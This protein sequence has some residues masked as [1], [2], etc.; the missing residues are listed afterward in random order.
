MIFYFSG[1]GNSFHA[2]TEIAKSQG[3]LAVSIAKE[4]DKGT[5]RYQFHKNELIG[6]VYPIYAWGPPQIVLD[7]IKKIKINGEKPY[8]FSISTC[9]GSEGNAT[10]LLQKVLLSKGLSLDSAFSLVMPDNY[11]F[12]A[13]VCSKDKAEK[14]LKSAEERLQVINDIIKKRQIGVF[15]LISGGKPFLNTAVIN[16]LFNRFARNTKKFYATDACTRCGLC[17]RICPVHSI[18]VKEKPIWGKDCTQCSACINRCPA[19]A[20]QYGAHTADRGRYVF[21]NE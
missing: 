16:P 20:I 12:G 15:Q 19:K 9:G 7:F 8:V 14:I 6:F 18:I 4:L 21:P 1:T 13:D 5:L 10:R 3:E 2:A 17:E 11:V